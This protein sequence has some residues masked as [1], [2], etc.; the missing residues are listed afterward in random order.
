MIL[1]AIVA[2]QTRHSVTQRYPMNQRGI[3]EHRSVILA[4]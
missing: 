3:S 1:R 2:D 4:V